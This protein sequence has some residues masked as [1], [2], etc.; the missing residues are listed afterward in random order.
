MNITTLK[1]RIQECADA[2]YNEDRPLVTDQEYD[3][4]MR[5]LRQME[6]EHPELI[7]VDSPTQVVGGK[8]VIGIP[9]EHRVPM[10]SLLDVFESSEVEQFIQDVQKSF[11]D[12]TFSVERKIDGLSLSLVYE[13][14]TLVQAST[15]GDGHVGED[16][17]DNV[18]VLDAVPN[19]IETDI[20]HLELRGECFMAEEDFERANMEQ[21]QKGKKLFANPRNCAAGTL[22][23]SDP[24]I[25]AKRN[26][27][28]IISTYR[29]AMHRP[30]IP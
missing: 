17:T 26:L 8:R 9:V 21:T 27:Q 20:H 13:D 1:K 24:A 3:E 6:S 5:Q 15:R 22:R 19:H 14:G 30:A 28:V 12:A 18:R 16:V 10:L 4:M 25:A 11:P 2:Y 29:K 7:T 23:Q